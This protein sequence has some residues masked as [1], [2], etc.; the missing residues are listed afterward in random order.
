M[1]FFLRVLTEH[2]QAYVT[3]TVTPSAFLYEYILLSTP[4]TEDTSSIQIVRQRSGWRISVNSVF[5]HG[6]RDGEWIWYCQPVQ[7]TNISYGLVWGLLH[8]ELLHDSS[9][10]GIRVLF[11]MI[12]IRTLDNTQID[13]A[14]LHNRR[15]LALHSKA[16]GFTQHTEQALIAVAL[17][18]GN[19][20]AFAA[21][22]F[23]NGCVT[24]IIV[25]G[26]WEVLANT[27][28]FE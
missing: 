4:A 19:R 2:E 28:L 12:H 9:I 18:H 15:R 8:R 5:F 20:Y 23:H 13:T 22:Q 26:S 11:S 24:H 7:H 21:S 6:V 14:I 17:K 25:G 27:R 1:H 3:P 10:D 16:G